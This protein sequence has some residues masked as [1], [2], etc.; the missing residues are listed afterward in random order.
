MLLKIAPELPAARVCTLLGCTLYFYLPG[1][2]VHGRA[3]LLFLSLTLKR[4]HA[5]FTAVVWWEDVIIFV[6]VLLFLCLSFWLLFFF[7]LRAQA[8]ELREKKKNPKL[9]NESR[10]IWFKAAWLLGIE[11]RR[12][13]PARPR[14][15]ISVTFSLIWTWRTARRHPSPCAFF[16]SLSFRWEIGVIKNSIYKQLKDE[17]DHLSPAAAS[18][19]LLYF[20]QQIASE[21]IRLL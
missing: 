19:F 4:F 2:S 17:F 1:W 14:D 20:Q 15:L 12:Q 9:K 3:P 10:L 7:L 8:T 18:G 5:A 21:L 13:K 11:N 16:F 6:C